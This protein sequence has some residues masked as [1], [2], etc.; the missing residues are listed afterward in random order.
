MRRAWIV[1]ALLACDSGPAGEGTTETWAYAVAQPDCAPW[2]GAATAVLLTNTPADSTE[3]VPFLRL[4][5]YRGVD[6]VRGERFEIGAA[7]TEGSDG[8]YCAAAG[9]CAAA[10]RGWIEFSA[11]PQG[12]A[13]SGRYD[14]VFPDGTRRAGQFSAPVRERQALCG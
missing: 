11:S 14:L 3:P 5:A 9:D 12:G 8:Y 13:L 1:L 2:D 7:G 10:A 6:G 4:A